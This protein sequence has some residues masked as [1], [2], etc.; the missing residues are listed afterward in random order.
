[1]HKKNFTLIELLVVS[2]VIAILA[3]L[4][5]PALSSS[6]NKARRVQ[7]LSNMKQVGTGLHAYSDASKGYMPCCRI[8]EVDGFTGYFT[9]ANVASSKVGL[10]L[11]FVGGYV[12]NPKVFFCTEPYFNGTYYYTYDN[13]DTGW[14]NWNQSGKFVD[15]S[16]TIPNILFS[17]G[18]LAAARSFYARAS[19]NPL[20]GE[21]PMSNILSDNTKQVVLSCYA[22]KYWYLDDPNGKPPHEGAG[23]NIVFGDNSGR[24]QKIE[25]GGPGGPDKRFTGD[26]FFG[27]L[28]A[29]ANR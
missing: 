19:A 11:L 28:N 21:F 9:G 6:R 12:T 1:M 24:W 27:W 2:G 7:D 5:L 29:H 8:G 14:A 4:L 15:L 10:G 25:W 26:Y 17:K 23:V 18:E 16:T 20:C 13:P 22:L 3:G